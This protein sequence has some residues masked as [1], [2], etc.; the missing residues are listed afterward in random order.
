MSKCDM[1]PIAVL[2]DSTSIN[3]ISKGQ[4]KMAQRGSQAVSRL[5]FKF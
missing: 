4:A 5:L 1:T 3:G 2:N